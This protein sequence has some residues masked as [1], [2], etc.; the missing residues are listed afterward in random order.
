VLETAKVTDASGN[1]VDLTAA[2]GDASEASDEAV[3]DD[4]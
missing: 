4:A 3:G 2:Y 1:A